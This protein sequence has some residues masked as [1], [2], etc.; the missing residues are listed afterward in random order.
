MH[1]CCACGAETRYLVCE[2]CLTSPR[3]WP[4]AGRERCRQWLYC[5]HGVSIGQRCGECPTGRSEGFQD[6]PEGG[7]DPQPIASS[8]RRLEGV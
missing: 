1:Y 8:Q 4:A 5:P 3:P 7:Y 2:A 6:A